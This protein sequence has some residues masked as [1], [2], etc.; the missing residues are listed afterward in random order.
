MSITITELMSRAHRTACDK[1][2][3]DAEDRSIGEQI[4]LMHSE[5]SEALEEVRNGKPLTQIYHSD[6]PSGPKPEGFAAELADV[7]IRVADT[8]E[9]YGVPLA[10]AVEEKLVY[11]AT[12]PYRHGG[13]AM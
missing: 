1:G 13:K 9:K 2:W 6:S 5:L 3:W 12:R 10:E 8:C 11:N 4:A 7:L